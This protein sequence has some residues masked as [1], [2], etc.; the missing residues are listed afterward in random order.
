MKTLAT[1]VVLVLACVGCGGDSPS[2]AV[3]GNWTALSGS[4]CV[5]DYSFASTGGF[6]ILF[7]CPLSNGAL[8]TEMQVGTFTVVQNQIQFTTKEATCT[9]A[10][11]LARAVPYGV[12]YSLSGSSLTLVYTDSEIVLERSTSTESTGGQLTYGCFDSTGAF[13]PHALAPI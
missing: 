10:A 1:V 9:D 12:A 13:T 2:D 4:A 11:T 3:V 6:A 5:I 8:G 7:G